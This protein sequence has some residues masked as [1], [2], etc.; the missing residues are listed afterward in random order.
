MRRVGLPDDPAPCS[1][2]YYKPASDVAPNYPTTWQ[3][4]EVPAHDSQAQ[5]LLAD[6]KTK[7]G[8]KFPNDV[9]HGK[10]NGDWTGVNYNGGQDPD[11]WWTYTQC[12]TPKSDTGLPADITTV[13]EPGSYGLTYDDGPNCANK[14][15]YDYLKSNNYKA[16][17]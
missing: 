16:T 13:P 8:Q 15:F 4:A 3:T 2:Y 1:G 11:C 17:L 10:P 5:A 14:P 12:T 7:L 6:I 9:A